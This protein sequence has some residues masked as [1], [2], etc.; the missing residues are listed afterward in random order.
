[1]MLFLTSK[2]FLFLSPASQLPGLKDEILLGAD[3]TGN[4]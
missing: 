3:V 4:T 2:D 1:M